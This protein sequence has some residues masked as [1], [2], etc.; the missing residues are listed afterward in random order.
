MASLPPHPAPARAEAPPGC[1][2]PGRQHPYVPPCAR[3]IR[4][5]RAKRQERLSI[6]HA[7]AEGRIRVL[8]AVVI[9]G[10]R[11]ARPP[12]VASFAPLAATVTLSLK[13][14]AWRFSA[15]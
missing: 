15:L 1:G 3:A 9:G 2:C 7:A 12:H 8:G 13:T 6:G 11:G 10:F 4:R 14:S 5:A